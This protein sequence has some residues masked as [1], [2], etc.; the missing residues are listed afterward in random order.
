MA[1]FPLFYKLGFR[2]VLDIYHVEYMLFL[3][4]LLAVFTLK[5]WRKVFV[6]LSF[7]ILGYLLTLYL[8]SYKVLNYNVELMEF[9][10]PLTIF[11]TAFSN[12]FKKRD[13]FHYYINMRKNYALALVFGGIHG[14]SYTT[15]FASITKGDF[16]VWEHFTSFFLGVTTGQFVI[17]FCFLFL[18]FIFLSIFGVNRRDWVMVISSGI[19]GVALT[20][21][22][23]SRYW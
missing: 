22:F 19:A 12:L 21:M 4:S 23:E 1:Q 7:F 9:L 14:F 3:I 5:D 20:F 18:S 11:I 8:G 17:A 16:K 15:Y 2:F 10:L 6:L 13:S